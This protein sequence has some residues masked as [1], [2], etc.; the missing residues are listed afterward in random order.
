M[1]DGW[2]GRQ[3]NHLFLCCIYLCHVCYVSVGGGVC[4]FKCISSSK[5]LN[6]SSYGPCW[7][8]LYLAHS[9]LF[10][11]SFHWWSLPLYFFRDDLKSS[12]FHKHVSWF[13]FQWCANSPDWISSTKGT[14]QSTAPHKRVTKLHYPHCLRA[15]LL[16]S[17][18]L[19]HLL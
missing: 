16:P 18:K 2:I 11:L 4:V 12:A 5:S 3:I 1:N 9:F 15:P 8:N 14:V 17:F 6:L 10:L 7:P 19:Y 13:K